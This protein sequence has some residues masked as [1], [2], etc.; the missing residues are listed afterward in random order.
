MNYLADCFLVRLTWMEATSERQRMVRPRK[1]HPVD[2]GLIPVFDR[3]GKENLGHALESAVRVE[4]ERRR[5]DVRY[6]VTREGFEVDFLAHWEEGGQTLI[7]VAADLTDAGTR[8]REVRALLAAA[9]SRPGA[10]P[11]LLTLTPEAAGRVP[12]E[13]EV[14]DAA[15][16][17][18]GAGRA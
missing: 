10:R 18:L 6:V 17:L 3:S 11:L 1:V 4:L 14:Q 16:W 8:E 5:A 9:R 12:D 7:Q 13:I 2:P 15:L